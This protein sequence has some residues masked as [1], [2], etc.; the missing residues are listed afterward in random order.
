MWN[1]RAQRK[2]P[3][4][5]AK[6]PRRVGR[7]SNTAG[8]VAAAFLLLHLP[9]LP[10]SLEDHDSINFA[11]GVRHFDVA[12][13]Q[14]HPPGYPLYILVAKGVHA[15]G[16]SEVHTL[17]LLSIVS[18]AL[19]ILALSALFRRL[20]RD[21]QGEQWSIFATVLTATAPLYWFTAARPL[22][23]M[24]GLAVAVAIQAFTLSVRSGGA[25]A[26]AAF[27][28]G[29]GGG[30]RSQVVWLTVPLIAL[31]AVRRPRAYRL[32]DA[33]VALGALVAGVIVW[34]VPM[35]WVTGGP[36]AYWHTVSDQGS[37]D[38]VGGA[39][40]WTTHTPQL[41]LQTFNGSF[42][43]P[44]ATPI[45]AVVALLLVAIGVVRLLWAGRPALG[46]LTVAFAPYLVFDLLFQD[47]ATTKYALPLVAPLT[48][49]A[50][51]GIAVLPRR[52][53]LAVVV[54]L[55]AA[56]MSVAVPSLQ[57]YAS[58]EAP[59]F[60]MLR[61]MRA[62]SPTLGAPP[63]FATHRRQELDMR[64][65][66][67]WMAE[68]LPSFS[69]R[70]PATPKREWLE[71]VKYWNDGGRAPVWFV[72]DPLRSDLALVDH[73][74]PR[75]Y[76]WPV[77]FPL[78]LGGIRPNGIDW[79]SLDSPGWYLGEGWALTP[80]TA[81]IADTG[82]Y[83]RGRAPSEGWIRRRSEPLT[84][85]IGGRNFAGDGTAA[86]LNIAIDGRSIGQP[87]V[88]PGF[89]LEMMTVPAEALSGPGDYGA[90]TVATRGEVAIE[91]FDAQ[92]ADRVVFGYGEGWYE[93]EYDG[94]TVWRWMSERGS[95]RL[96]GTGQALVLSLDG[97]TEN[98]SKPSRITIRIGDRIVAQQD[99]GKTFSL[100]VDLPPDVVGDREHPD[101]VIT[102][103]TDQV[104]I[105]AEL[106][107]RT[108]DRRHLGLKV[109]QCRLG[110]RRPS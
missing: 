21:P 22:S 9:F 50:L 42:V 100:R 77:R 28:A 104:Y 91:Q 1:S 65:P 13:H 97:V 68:E 5:S 101:Q 31:M 53:A 56:N 93:M 85:M 99:V 32:E 72:A 19:S 64:R 67:A 106:S 30:F 44:W 74:E 108:E 88:Q 76:R 46:I 96:R 82:K 105:P 60:R 71:F 87:D 81:G 39:M 51:Q 80:E 16:A 17:S 55:I 75:A 25:L 84:L 102:I 66:M 73:P 86:S 94:A 11:L 61:D 6:V 79:Y 14:P 3:R 43:A 48:Y 98:F 69:Q 109:L 70:L 57:A 40:L 78:L 110:P 89:F 12:Q 27:M 24:P 41:L 62:S 92:S 7:S 8:V 15:I 18:G 63:V 36:M 35:V 59:A 95:L 37:K 103:E 58:E 2:L 33:L 83:G 20:D 38:F 23:D 4:E 90:L 29:L 47:T 26:L 10:A 45:L 54:L 34:F 52:A 49:L 107:S